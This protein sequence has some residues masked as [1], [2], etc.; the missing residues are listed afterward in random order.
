MVTVTT[1]HILALALAS[2]GTLPALAAGADSPAI[3]LPAATSGDRVHYHVRGCREKWEPGFSSRG[4]PRCTESD[5]DIVTRFPGADGESLWRWTVHGVHPGYPVDTLVRDPQFLVR[6]AFAEGVFVE[7]AIDAQGKPSR[8]ADLVAFRA[9]LQHYAE[10][11]YG[12]NAAKAQP[13]VQAV[14]AMPDAALLGAVSEYPRALGW[15]RNVPLVPGSTLDDVQSMDTGQGRVLQLNRHATVSQPSAD[16]QDLKVVVD[17][18]LDAAQARALVQ[19]AAENMR[20][21]RSPTAKDE[22]QIHQALTTPM[23]VSFNA[24]TTVDPRSPW[25]RSVVTVNTFELGPQGE[26]E[27]STYTRE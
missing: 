3:A 2:S 6:R 27:E 18:S 4:A 22:E 24:T 11:L 13:L 23:K 17:M 15:F 19:A 21:Q 16:D 5:V 1:R 8:I 12:G 9:R 25:P 10:T 14:Q 26:H 20:K 7:L